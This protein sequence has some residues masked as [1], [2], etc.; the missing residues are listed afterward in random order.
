MGSVKVA[1]NYAADILPNISAKKAGYPI[2][3]Y[4]DSK[5]NEYVEEFSTSNFIAVDKATGAFV[6]PLS[7]AILPS[8]TNKSLMQ[9]AADE[10]HT[11]YH[12][13]SFSCMISLCNCAVLHLM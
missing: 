7:S 6:T 4:L 1:G 5:T 12:P 2:V 3:L 11:V 9:L 13:F 10:G 8:I